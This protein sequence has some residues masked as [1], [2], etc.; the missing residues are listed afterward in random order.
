MNWTFRLTINHD[1]T[2]SFFP[3]PKLKWKPRTTSANPLAGQSS[4]PL[5]TTGR[6]TRTRAHTH[7]ETEITGH[8]PTKTHSYE[9]ARARRPPR[10][11]GWWWRGRRGTGSNSKY[12]QGRRRLSSLPAAWQMLSGWGR[13]LGQSSL[14]KEKMIIRY[15]NPKYKL[16]IFTSLKPFLN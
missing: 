7:T 11:G 1:V 2:H 3:G 13:H 12:Q 15:P 8:T 6:K 4:P 14:L 5:C 16:K 9:R 10:P